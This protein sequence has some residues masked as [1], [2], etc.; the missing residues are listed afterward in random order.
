MKVNL[1]VT[2]L[3]LD[4]K[5]VPGEKIIA[6]EQL[7]NLV[8]ADHGESVDK[9]IEAFQLNG[10]MERIALAKKEVELSD[11]EIALLEKVLDGAIEGKRANTFLVGRLYGILEKGRKDA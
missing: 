5:K 3:G 7:A 8:M 10:L 4:G 6:S 1:N 9:A 11:K 2:I